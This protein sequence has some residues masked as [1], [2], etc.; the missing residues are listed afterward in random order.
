MGL[1]DAIFGRWLSRGERRPVVLTHE[2]RGHHFRSG[3]GTAYLAYITND[4]TTP[5][6]NVRFGVEIDGV[7]IPYR[8]GDDDDASR[9]NVV[10]PGERV[11]PS[12]AW[13]IVIPDDFLFASEESDGGR[14]YWC[15]YRSPGGWWWETRN[16]WARS[17]NFT[18]HSRSLVR[19]PRAWRERRALARSL[20]DGREKLRSAH[21]E[22]A[23]ATGDE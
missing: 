8:F 12:D 6:H 4:G 22:L 11:P 19:R 14:I 18:I 20:R 15:N 21:D 2:A 7:R 13:E 9:I 5:A 16:P 10:R 23:S 17:A 3:G 1:T